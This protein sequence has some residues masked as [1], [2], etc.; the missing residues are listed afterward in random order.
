MK[1]KRFSDEAAPFVLYSSVCNG[2]LAKYEQDESVRLH[3]R[4]RK[5]AHRF[6]IV[7]LFQKGK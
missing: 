1:T 2:L 3:R 7:V 6:F 4:M 5:E